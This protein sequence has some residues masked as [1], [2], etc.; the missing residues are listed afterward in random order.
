MTKA[1]RLRQAAQNQHYVPKFIL[2]NFLGNA[3]KEQVH[4]FQK[5]TRKGFTTSIANI[6]AER[7]FH[8]FQIDENHIASFEE[9][10]CRIE[11]MVL[12]AY[13]AVLERGTLD[14]SSQEQAALIAFITFQFVRTRAQ[15]ELFDNMHAQLA[16]HLAQTGESIDDFDGYEPLDD[17]TRALQHI[18][19][20]RQS[21][22]GFMAALADKDLFLMNAAQGRSFYLSDNPVVLHND[23]PTDGIYGNLG[24]ACP[25]IQ[26]YVPLSA[27]LMLGAWCPSLIREMR[28]RNAQQ[29]RELAAAILSPAM[30]GVTSRDEFEEAMN[31]LRPL[32]ESIEALMRHVDEGTPTLLNSE[33]MDFQNSL[34]VAF[35]SEHVICK[36]ADFALAQRFMRENPH[37]KG[38]NLTA[39]PARVRSK[40][41]APKP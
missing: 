19:F 13:K 3:V 2:R 4:V 40:A 7:R 20:I 38:F 6:M 5:S 41:R 15:R 36:Q 24:L 12:P 35:A 14:R 33:N 32:R 26:I 31:R 9:A 29:K 27:E 30:R 25:G 28:A 17:N 16:D 10:V 18:R 37:Q 11:D 39:G 21:M 22:G 23:R 8:E 1:H 34:Q